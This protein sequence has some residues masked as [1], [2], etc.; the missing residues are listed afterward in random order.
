MYNRKKHTESKVKTAMARLEQYKIVNSEIV[1]T[2]KIRRGVRI[3][4]LSK[5]IGEL[6]FRGKIR[7]ESCRF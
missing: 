3:S 7:H 5:E 2:A 6:L 1:K 4:E